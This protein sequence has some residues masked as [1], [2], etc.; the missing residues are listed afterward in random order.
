MLHITNGDCAAGLIRQSGIPGTVLPWRD[1]L[2]EGPVPAD[3]P[4]AALSRLRARF[5]AETGWSDLAAA[6][7]A[8]AERDAILARGTSEEEVV[9]WFEHDLYDQ[10]QLLQLLDW[11]A[12]AAVRPNRLTLVCEATYLGNASSPQLAALFHKRAPVSDAAL[13]LARR[14]WAAFRAPDP[15]SIVALLSGDSAALEFLAPALRR[16]LEQF[17]GAQDGLS[18]SERQA[19]QA[20]EAGVSRLGPLYR[21]AHHQREEAIFLGDA[22]FA[23]YLEGLARVREP[24]LEARDGKPLVAPRR[25]TDGRDFWE[26]EV[27]LT[28]A[29]RAVIAGRADHARLNGIDRWLGGV[30]LQGVEPRWRWDGAAGRLVE[31]DVR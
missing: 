28:S 31:T 13:A 9:L 4:I 14:G 30:H 27:V 12:N 3:L 20:I 1:V 18:R 19:L 7:Q 11:H 24:S 16:H 21:A 29:G 22:V 5:I 25:E 6:E 15:R 2:H 8:F 10:L 23:L 17:P 26:R